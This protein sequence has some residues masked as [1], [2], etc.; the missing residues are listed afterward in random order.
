[1]PRLP[2]SLGPWMVTG[3]PSKR[4]SPLSNGWMPA[5]HLISVD[6]PAPLSPTR[7]MT[8]PDETW[9]STSNSAW[10]APKL[11]ETPCSSRTGVSVTCD[12]SSR[13]ERTG[14]A[15]GGAPPGHSLLKAGLLALVGQLASADLLHLGEVHLA[16]VL[17]DVVLGDGHRVQ[18]DRRDVVGLV[19]DRR[20]LGRRLLALGQRD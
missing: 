4:I 6:L 2:A 9:K 14:G 20:G 10:T 18:Q 1:M 5:M 13:P 12:S 8:S 3:R 7:A 19:V 17:R 11:F 16:G 15:P